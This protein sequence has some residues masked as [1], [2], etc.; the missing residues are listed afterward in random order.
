MANQW[1]YR[2]NTAEHGPFTPSQMRQ[3][4]AEGIIRPETRVRRGTDSKWRSAKR[5]QGLL[6]PAKVASPPRPPAQPAKVEP[7]NHENSGAESESLPPS[8]AK[9]KR[10]TGVTIICAAAFVVLCVR[11]VLEANAPQQVPLEQSEAAPQEAVRNEPWRWSDIAPRADPTSTAPVFMIQEHVEDYFGKYLYLD[12]VWIHEPKKLEDVGNLPEGSCRVPITDN[13]GDYF[14]SLMFSNKFMFI[15]PSELADRWRLNQRADVKI[16]GKIFF[17][18]GR[19]E[20]GRTTSLA[21]RKGVAFVY[22]IQTYNLAGNPHSE[23]TA[24]GMRDLLQDHP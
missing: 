13:R 22:K 24:G 18:V 12:R 7:V 5:V 17:R 20:P 2:S 1:Y 21:P 4:A 10:F 9:S 3:L 11:I 14:M 8:M 15:C 19:L 23:Y 16:R 6:T